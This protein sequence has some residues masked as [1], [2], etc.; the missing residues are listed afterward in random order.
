MNVYAIIHPKSTKFPEACGVLSHGVVFHT[1]IA[2]A[3]CSTQL[4]SYKRLTI[5][6]EMD[7]FDY[8]TYADQTQFIMTKSTM[9]QSDCL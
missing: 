9:A 3:I 7:Y 4:Y 2:T 1:L 5:S 6:D 8:P